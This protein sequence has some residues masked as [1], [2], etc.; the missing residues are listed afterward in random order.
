MKRVVIGALL[1]VSY[2]SALM[3]RQD[4]TTIRSNNL[5]GPELRLSYGI[6]TGMSFVGVGTD[7]RS[8]YVMGA[9]TGVLEVD[10]QYHRNKHI[11]F[12]VT[13]AF[14]SGSGAWDKVV[15]RRTTHHV[16]YEA[17]ALGN[18]KMQVLT[19]APEMQFSYFRIFKGFVRFYGTI[20][21]GFSVRDE[22]D[23]YSGPYYYSHFSNGVNSLGSSMVL[24]SV[25]LNLTPYISPFGIR[26]GRKFSGFM[27]GGLG[28]RGI[29]NCGVAYKF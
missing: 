22:V 19:I 28:Y 2:S 7:Y 5:H 12:G 18:Y 16:D 27:Q 10:C 13:I 15:V 21:L 4:S 3:A 20:G 24:G 9:G 26:V 1:I 23:T 14:E 25:L 6:P 17:T 11:A 29:F 8:P